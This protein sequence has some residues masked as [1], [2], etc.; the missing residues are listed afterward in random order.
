MK[1]EYSLIVEFAGLPGAGKTTICR[2]V[3]VPHRLKAS[4]SLSEM[5]LQLALFPVAWHLFMLCIGT[6]PFDWSRLL[7]APSLV[8][9]LRCYATN[10]LPTVL[11]RGVIQKIWS[12]LMDSRLYSKLR[13]KRLMVA[14][15]PFAPHCI[16]WVETPLEAAAL[17][18]S[19]R[20]HGNSRFDRLPLE[21]INASLTE[22]SRLLS[23]LVEIYQQNTGAVLLR[24][25]GR[26]PAKDNAGIIDRLVLKAQHAKRSQSAY[27]E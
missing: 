3:T 12:I 5:R 18:I 19:Q 20:S 17:R 23:E 27:T 24:L 13:L 25:D 22:K 2:H 9:L 1:E 7:R 14:I 8:M 6:R 26:A 4:V 11:D 16:A 15:R 10:S 21:E